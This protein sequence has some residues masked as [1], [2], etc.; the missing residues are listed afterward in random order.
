M[1]HGFVDDYMLSLDGLHLG[2]HK[3]LQ[4]RGKGL[5]I[6][7]PAGMYLRISSSHHHLTCVIALRKK[8]PFRICKRDSCQRQEKP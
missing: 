2:L 7:P 6:S 8:I 3:I 5:H 1:I 4:I